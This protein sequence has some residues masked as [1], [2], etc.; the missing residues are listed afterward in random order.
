MFKKKI[1]HTTHLG[2]QLCILVT[3]IS[4]WFIGPALNELFSQLEPV[5]KESIR[6]MPSYDAMPEVSF[7]TT[8]SAKSP[9][10]IFDII[11][12]YLKSIGTLAL[13]CVQII[14]G[15]QQYRL[16]KRAKK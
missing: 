10:A 2:L 15:I 13:V 12:A 6:P 7:P 3:L 11:L 4:I 8:E 16:R 14:L 5:S 9:I 1:K